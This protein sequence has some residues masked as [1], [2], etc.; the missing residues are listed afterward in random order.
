MLYVY[1]HAYIVVCVCV[2]MYRLSF[3]RRSLSQ[4]YRLSQVY[5]CMHTRINLFVYKH[6]H[7]CMHVYMFTFIQ[8]KMCA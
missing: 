1:C 7:T 4:A 8:I 6:V 3:T 2:C 5:A